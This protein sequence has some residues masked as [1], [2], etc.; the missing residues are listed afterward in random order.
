MYVPID[1]DPNL[2]VKIDDR[3]LFTFK[4]K[5]QRDR[6]IKRYYD[7]K[8]RKWMLDNDTFINKCKDY[9]D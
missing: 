3:T 2:A 7:Q 8:S 1:I 6:F 4:N 9:D 5:K